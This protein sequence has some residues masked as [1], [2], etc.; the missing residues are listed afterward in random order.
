MPEQQLVEK[1]WP[2]C[3]THVEART[4]IGQLANITCDPADQDMI[5]SF[6]RS[7]IRTIEPAAETHAVNVT[8]GGY[9]M[10]SRYRLKQHSYGGGHGGYIEVLEVENPP[11][12]RWPIVFHV[13]ICDQGH[14]FSEWRSV[15][16]AKAAYESFFNLD[17]GREKLEKLPGFRRFVSCHCLI[18]WFYAIGTEE[19]WGDFALPFGLEDDP[20]YR[21]GAQFVVF[22]RE[23]IPQIKTCMGTRFLTVEK[24]D[25]YRTEKK[26]YRLVHWHDGSVWS[27]LNSGPPPRPVLKNEAWITDAVAQFQKLL[28]GRQ[29]SIVIEFSNGYRFAG[30]LKLT[31]KRKPGSRAGNYLLRVKVSGEDKPR[32]GWVENWEPTSEL[33][34]IR[35]HVMNRSGHGTKCNVEEIKIL[36]YRRPHSNKWQ[37][38]YEKP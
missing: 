36:K 11:D 27:E 15:T 29:N 13:Y 22:D 34:T 19:L 3:Y 25:G 2:N 31:G 37:G 24:I 7:H 23:Q 30:Q 6:V 5:K 38:F 1:R 33:P 8:H 21:L 35:D 9:G 20:V 26:H 16:A 28:A 32:E 18:P 17:C 12:D 10:Y 4:A 14:S